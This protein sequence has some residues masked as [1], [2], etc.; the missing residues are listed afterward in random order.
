MDGAR[1]ATAGSFGLG[2]LGRPVGPGL[3]S[4]G[5]LLPSLLLAS[6]VPFR[7]LPLLAKLLP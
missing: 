1:T 2:K 5:H 3:K 4:P 6:L 7:I